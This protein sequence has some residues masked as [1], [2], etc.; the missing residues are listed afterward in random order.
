MI[1][2]LPRRL[3]ALA[4]VI[5]MLLLVAPPA[6]ADPPSVGGALIEAP[7]IPL[8][9]L[10]AQST[11]E[12]YPHRELSITGLTFAVPEGLTPASLNA[13]LEIP[14]N[15]RF[16]NLTVTQDDRTISRLELP[17]KD[18]TPM[19]I[20]LAGT[21]VTGNSVSLTLTATV[22]PLENYCWDPL[23]P[24][25]LVNGSITFTGGEV[26]P[27]TIADFLPPV[28]RKLTIV[29][30]PKPTQQETDAAVQLAA[31]LE[32]RYGG[33]N[34]QVAVEALYDRS[35]TAVDPSLPLERQI[36]IREGPEKGLALQGTTGVPSLV[37]SGT[38]DDLTNQTRLLTDP[39][40][41]FADGVTA[42]AGPL[43]N[44]QKLA[45]D[46]TTLEQL[47]QTGLSAEDLWPDVS[48]SLEQT[49]WGHSLDHIRVHVLGSHTP[50]P[51]NFGGEVLAS[52]AGQTVNRWPAEANGTIDHW[53]DIPDKLLSR[54]T[55]LSIKVHTTGDA[56]HCGEYL[57]IT[58]KIDPKT[59]V[60]TGRA[61]PPMP[62]GFPSIPQS[63]MTPRIQVGITDDAF[64]DTVRAV[65]I[66]VG[67]QQMS[68]VPL[69]TKV[70][71]LKQAIDSH[72][73]AV[74]ISA[75]AWP[76]QTIPL[77]FNAENGNI[78]IEGLD[79]GG[80]SVSLTLDPSIHFGSLQT[81]YDGHRSIL[82]ATSNAAPQQLDELLRWLAAEPGRWFGLDGREV[83]DVPGKEP[84]TIANPPSDIAVPQPKHEDDYTWLWWIGGAWV[85]AVAIGGGVLV[86][87]ARRNSV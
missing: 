42:V 5:A 48:I 52:V 63:L 53:V 82:I 75:G 83:I 76:V 26:A 67:L 11:I 14:V 29:V 60:Q 69:T 68:A 8:P 16:G 30:P 22:L 72:D 32:D 7:T 41:K 50:L 43:P 2:S 51:N 33:Q 57:P 19:V 61:D 46:T 78:T 66:V 40:V 15:L 3:G 49:R 39:S 27:K 71:S 80:E 34:P 58:L 20:P 38:G 12:F 13:T 17:T 35:S 44:K 86:Y 23:T 81:T 74:L 1:R 55:S 18:Q 85:L 10:G 36:I 84:I 4:G 62:K 64:N 54:A 6:T 31:A 21:K 65:Q 87:R 45:A 24:I 59:E 56:G 9:N 77:P 70:T 47:N 25:R 79:S 37:I 28:I 73:P